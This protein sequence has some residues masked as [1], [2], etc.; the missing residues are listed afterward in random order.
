MA[1]IPEGVKGPSQVE[2]I[3]K[4]EGNEGLQKPASQPFSSY[5]QGSNIL[6]ATTPQISP[7]DL[8]QEGKVKPG[9][10]STNSVLKQMN[11]TSNTLGVMQDQLQTKNL[12]LKPSQSHLLRNKLTD[13]NEKIRSATKAVGVQDGTAVPMKRNPIERFLALLSDGQNRLNQAQ[14]NLSQLGN[15]G[16]ELSFPEMMR[17]QIQLSKA[18]RSVE[19][20][21]IMLSKFLSNIQMLFNTQI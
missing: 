9:D 11:S 3:K 13:A 16:K 4:I 1:E 2:P 18:Q 10:V 17:I 5:M 19:F 21:S 20:A 12:E 7:F 14:S 15:D 6:G 8:L